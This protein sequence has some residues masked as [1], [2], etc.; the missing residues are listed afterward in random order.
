L[1]QIT[2]DLG[3]RLHLAAQHDLVF[4]LK[5]KKKSFL[6]NPTTDV[7]DS[8]RL[9]VGFAQNRNK[10]DIF[11]TTKRGWTAL[12]YPAYGGYDY[13]VNFKL[14]SHGMLIHTPRLPLYIA[15][16]H[17]H[18][19]LVSLLLQKGADISV[20]VQIR[21]AEGSTALHVAA[22][23]GHLSVVDVLLKASAPHSKQRPTL[24]VNDPRGHTT[25]PT[26]ILRLLISSDI[27]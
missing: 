19:K 4:I 16:S 7:D 22:L 25:S 11:S 18:A 23:K 17:G 26:V 1:N 15:A 2:R 24:E 9:L 20:S 10:H 27:S 12:H 14:S 6:K 8:I 13:I 5:K 3:V 21:D